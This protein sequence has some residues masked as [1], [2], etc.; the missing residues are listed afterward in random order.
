MKPIA[1]GCEQGRNDDVEALLAAGMSGLERSLVCP[2]L[3][4]HRSRRTSRQQRPA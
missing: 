2:Y 3:S 4:S 1:A